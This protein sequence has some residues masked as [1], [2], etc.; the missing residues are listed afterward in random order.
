MFMDL[1]QPFAI[2]LMIGLAVGIDRERRVMAGEGTMGVRT[3]AIIAL[4]GTVASKINSAAVTAG[5]ML[6]LSLVVALGYMRATS[7]EFS[8]H[9]SPPEDEGDERKSS[10]DLGLTTEVSAA[11]VF[12]LGYLAIAERVLAGILGIVLVTTLYSRRYLHFFSRKFLQPADIG[13]A[14]MLSISAFI[15]MPS[16]PADPVDPWGL[17]IPRR[18]MQ[19]MLLIGSTEFFGYLIQ[20]IL[21]VR[22]GALA[23][24]FLG[25]L[26][27]S[28]AI[29]LSIARKT[30]RD[31]ISMPSAI[32]AALAATMATLLLFVAVIATTSKPLVS[33]AGIPVLLAACVAGLF[34]HFSQRK[35]GHQLSQQQNRQSPLD[36]RRVIVLSGV[37]GGLL[38]LTAVVKRFV[39]T[40]AFSAV[41]FLSGLFELQATTFAAAMLHQSQE[42]SADS[43]THALLLAALASFVSKLGISW[44]LGSVRFAL[45]VSVALI[46]S[47]GIGAAYYAGM[48]FY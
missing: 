12:A 5:L 10:I 36:L 17:L 39:G 28:T 24:G 31:E 18:I 16:L 45:S 35:N 34:G 13:A 4:L 7:P 46:L 30:K 22:I 38:T 26:V 20:R 15:I 27:S 2:S 3:F 48:V 6:L 37:V 9:A 8:G 1:L 19:I 44:A 32:G 42:V 21:G 11:L 23:A 14:L 29:F 47:A 40:A 25:G 33:S 43:A 41:S